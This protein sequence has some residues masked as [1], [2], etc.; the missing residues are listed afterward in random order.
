MGAGRLTTDPNTYWLAMQ[1]NGILPWP[2][3][4]FHLASALKHSQIK[5]RRSKSSREWPM[6]EKQEKNY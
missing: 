6:K 2:H 4:Q 5:R 1:A 3:F